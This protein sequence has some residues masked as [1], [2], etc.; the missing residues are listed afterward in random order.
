MQ[1]TQNSDPAKTFKA[2]YCERYSVPAARFDESLFWRAIRWYALPLVFVVKIVNANYFR[3]DYE[4]IRAVGS[5]EIM[6]DVRAEVAAFRWECGISSP[7]R[8]R[9]RLRVSTSRIAKLAKRLLRSDRAT[10]AS[11]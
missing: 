8:R 2:I 5:C 9:L 10:T 1:P 3:P 4:F 6:D 11:V 7:L